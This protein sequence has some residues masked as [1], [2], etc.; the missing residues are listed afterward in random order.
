MS[1]DDE[2]YEDFVKRYRAGQGQ[3]AAGPRFSKVNIRLAITLGLGLL[4]Y[5][6]FSAI[7]RDLDDSVANEHVARMQEAQGAINREAVGG[8]NPWSK[9]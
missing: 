2:N 6:A 4:F 3:P 8:R 7:G 5:L 9:D 1:A